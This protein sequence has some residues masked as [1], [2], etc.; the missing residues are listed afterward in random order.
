MYLILALN[1]DRLPL[2]CAHICKNQFNTHTFHG[3]LHFFASTNSYVSLFLR[4]SHTT[5]LPLLCFWQKDLIFLLLG[6]T[7]GS[8]WLL[9]R[10][11]KT[12]KIVPVVQVSHTQSSFA[13]NYSISLLGSQQVRQ[14]YG[15][16]GQLKLLNQILLTPHFPGVRPQS[17]EL[18][19]ILFSPSCPMQ[20]ILALL[21]FPNIPWLSLYRLLPN[22][23]DL[24][25]PHGL[26]D[27]NRFHLPPTSRAYHWF[28]Q[29]LVIS[30]TMNLI[31]PFLNTKPT[32]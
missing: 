2:L 23:P 4:S 3:G 17:L 6:F 5:S 18:S 15:V 27:F 7:Y 13:P 12:P 16:Q 20:E 14:V 21:L 9:Q 30:Q 24:S 19:L 10:L 31:R 8:S 28:S 26:N 32:V 11:E 1:T 25:K 29:E 22:H